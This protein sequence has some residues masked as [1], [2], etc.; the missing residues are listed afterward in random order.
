MTISSDHNICSSLSWPLVF[1][2]DPSMLLCFVV[3]LYLLS[4]KCFSIYSFYRFRIF[5][6]SITNMLRRTCLLVCYVCHFFWNVLTVH[7]TFSL[8]LPES[9]LLVLF[10]VCILSYFEC[11]MTFIRSIIS[12]IHFFFFLGMILMLS[13]MLLLRCFTLNR[14]HRP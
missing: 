3:F 2:L 7:F 1:L 9:A 6:I 4:W 14:R 11:C 10:R 8:F 5:S 12:V 13:L